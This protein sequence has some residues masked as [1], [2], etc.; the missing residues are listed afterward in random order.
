ML[1]VQNR[2]K[3]FHFLPQIEKLFKDFGL[4]SA[5][6][7]HPDL[8]KKLS[9]TLFCSPPLKKNVLCVSLPDADLDHP[10]PALLYHRPRGGGGGE[11]GGGGT[12]R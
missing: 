5:S 12:I 4:G 8:I 3:Y 10:V 1:V 9:N 7:Q 6:N 11:R 2:Y